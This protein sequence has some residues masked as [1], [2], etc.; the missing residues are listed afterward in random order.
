MYYI[1]FLNRVP[2][3]FV[4]KEVSKKSL[5]LVDNNIYV[6]LSYRI[7]FFKPNLIS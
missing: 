3:V 4:V 6:S 7:G 5:V 1:L 2:I